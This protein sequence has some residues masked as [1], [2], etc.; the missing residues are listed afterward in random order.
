MHSA[1]FGTW[2]STSGAGC[3]VDG[4]TSYH[5]RFRNSPGIDYGPNGCVTRNFLGGFSFAGEAQVIALITNYDQFADTTGN[6]IGTDQS[7]PPE[8]GSTNGF[9]TEFEHNGHMLVHGITGGHMGT[10]WSPADPLFWL[11]HSNV[12]RIW[13]TWQDY[14]DHDECSTDEYYAP[15][16]YDSEWAL[17][18]RLP[19]MAASSV[20]SWDFRM[21]YSAEEDSGPAFPTV[22][23]VMTNDGPD[24]S[25]RYMNSN[26]NN[27]IPGYT[28]NPRL[29]QVATDFVGVKCNRDKWEWTRRRNLEEEEQQQ[30]LAEEE[31]SRSTTGDASATS[32]LM[33]QTDLM[34]SGTHD[35][36]NQI[37]FPHFFRSSLRG[38]DA[39][40]IEDDADSYFRTKGDGR[41]E[42]NLDLDQSDIV[43]VN[44]AACAH[45]PVFTLQETRVEWNRLCRE[46]PASTSVADRLALL[47][48]SDCNRKGNPRSD[49]PEIRERI[50]MTMMNAFDGPSSSYECFHRPDRPAGDRRRTEQG[51]LRF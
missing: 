13:G 15:W 45:P 17:D 7:N 48:K 26:L 23:D 44:I 22:R 39:Q 40:S 30:K 18:R 2:G 41:V 37:K 50:S 20:S 16:H 35:D 3:T 38:D 51:D 10:N 12:D 42:S 28:A 14:W 31:S 4:I 33:N 1:T 34:S 11:H 9:R 32:I 36:E 25:V 43:D 8:T 21:A 46:L 29:F 19:F 5:Q 47:A 27:L 49:A 6:A 24:L